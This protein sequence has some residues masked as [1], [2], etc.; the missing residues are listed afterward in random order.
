MNKS[1]LM[2]RKWSDALLCFEDAQEFSVK[3]LHMFFKNNNYSI[4]SIY[5]QLSALEINGLLR[6][7]RRGV[8]SVTQKGVEKARVAKKYYSSGSV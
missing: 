1:S 7:V 6:R 5:A 2:S 8:Y 4:V 3:H